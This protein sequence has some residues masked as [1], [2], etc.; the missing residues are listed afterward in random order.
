[1]SI[2][3]RNPHNVRDRIFIELVCQGLRGYWLP[4]NPQSSRS[5]HFT[6]PQV[7][8]YDVEGTGLHTWMD[9]LPHFHGIV[10]LH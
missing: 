9:Q 2:Y 1:M 7:Y 10:H 6:E 8:K 4:M 3:L 5:S